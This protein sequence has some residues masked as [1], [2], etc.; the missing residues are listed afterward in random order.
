MDKPAELFTTIE[1]W[2]PRAAQ[3]SYVS[4]KRYANSVHRKCG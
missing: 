3:K 2:H 1:V 4:E